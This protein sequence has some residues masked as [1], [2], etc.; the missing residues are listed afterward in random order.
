MQPVRTGKGRHPWLHTIGKPCPSLKGTFPGWDLAFPVL[1]GVR[2][3]CSLSL[4]LM[5]P[6]WVK[7]LRLGGH[8]TEILFWTGPWLGC[9]MSLTG[10]KVRTVDPQRVVAL[11][12]WGLCRLEEGDS[13]LCFITHQVQASSYA[14]PT[15]G[16]RQYASQSWSIRTPRNIQYQ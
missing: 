16:E 4:W 7:L 3:V 12:G 10:P 13:A 6:L 1:P 8:C 14:F 15:S 11:E 5:T 9:E 2:K